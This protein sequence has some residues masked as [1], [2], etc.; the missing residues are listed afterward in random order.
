M[1][2]DRIVVV[3]AVQLADARDVFPLDRCSARD[4]VFAVLRTDV[5]PPRCARWRAPAAPRRRSLDGPSSGKA[6]ASLHSE[7]VVLGQSGMTMGSTWSRVQCSRPVIHRWS[8]FCSPTQRRPLPGQQAL[9]TVAAATHSSA[10]YFPARV[11]FQAE[12][13]FPSRM[14]VTL[15]WR[16]S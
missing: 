11:V 6:T 4:G 14:K 8:T 12:D 3:S 2:R 13:F 15:P 9:K 16:S 5:S 10:G 7:V 1:L